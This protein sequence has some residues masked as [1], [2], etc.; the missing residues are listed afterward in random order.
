MLRRSV[1]RFPNSPALLFYGACLTYQDL[2][3]LATR[4][5]ISLRSL[6]VRPQ[7]RVA[8]MLPNLPQALIA[9]YG[10][11][12]AG[13]VV[14]Q[15][16]PLYVSREIEAQL[17][18]SGSE[19]M[20]ALDLFHSRIEPIRDRTALRRTILTGVQDFLPPLRRLLYPIK[21]RMSG[22][23]TRI[24]KHPSM[25]DF[26]GL[27]KGSAEGDTSPLPSLGPDDL[28]LLQ[29]SGGTTGTAK[30]VMLTHRN[31]VANAFQC[32]YWVPDFR[33]GHEV[34]LGVIPFFHAYGL[35]TCQ[36]LAVLAGCPL[37][38]LPRFQITEVLEAIQK[39]R[40]TIFSGI[41]AMF[42]KLSESPKVGRYDLRSLRV[43][44]SGA[45]P[46][47]AEVQDRFRRLIGVEISEGYGLTEASPV[48]H[49][50]PVYG[51][52]PEGSIGVPFPDTDVRLVDLDSGERAV[53]AGGLGE[54]VVRGPQVMQGY[55][56][57]PSETHSVLRDGWLYTGDIAREDARG[58][59][60]LVDRKKD[61]I[62]S[63]GETVY[64][65]EVEDVLCGHPAVQDAVVVG[66][67]DPLLGE[68]VKAY[69]VLADGHRLSEQELIGYCRQGLAKFKVPSTVE[70]R[71]ELPRTFVGKAL[72]RV[73]RE[74]AAPKVGVG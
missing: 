53:P 25:Y 51:E 5:A 44:L 18:D 43:C 15:I 60:Y 52:H 3:H 2:D 38:L 71:Q 7:D 4:F 12:L 70:F 66:V 73:L 33:E 74:E 16:N 49:C 61:M 14:V 34:F 54:L 28:A 64:P 31:L 9:Y 20:V 35:S 58:F 37:I 36:H 24:K 13:A 56:N 45:S 1:N 6:G 39:Y 42:M 19:T 23:W 67:P 50:N 48:T 59:F 17:N 62:K 32:R 27:L 46:L 72:R 40:V 26:L 8:I 10:A 47:R 69:V 11:L 41:P 65:R 57:K 55:W 63:R 29:Y 30:G 22:H 68:A 21:A